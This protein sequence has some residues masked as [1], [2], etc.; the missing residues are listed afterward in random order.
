MQ[1][2]Y[3]AWNIDLNDFW[4]LTSI[5]ERLRFLVGFGVLAPSSHNSQ[6]WKFEIQEKENAII[7]HPDFARSLPY[8]DAN[9]RQLYISLG[10]A[11]ENI[12]VAGTCYGLQPKIQI[13]REKNHI[14][15]VITC[16][17]ISFARTKECDIFI[18][19]ILNRRTNRNKYDSRLPDQKFI[20]YAQGLKT[21][22]IAIDFISDIQKKTA[23]A[24]IVLAATESAMSSDEFRRE[25][26]AYVKSNTTASPIGIPVFGMGIPTL[27]SYIVPF[28]LKYFNMSR[29]SRT[30]DTELLKK[31][32]PM[33]CIISTRDDNE[34]SWIKVGQIYE[35]LALYATHIGISTATMAAPIQIGE[36]YTD[37]QKTLKTSFRPQYFCRVGYT[38]MNVHKSPRL[39]EKSVI[40]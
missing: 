6:P 23:I 7:I 9:N 37:I 1:E 2:N 17:N 40:T 35:Q 18:K 29:I 25:L 31:H 10:C 16:D 13:T 14:L 26:S 30:Q 19:T 15:I 39:M 33:M 3:Q 34:A 20:E 27:M 4:K 28:L 22:A 21:D 5:A 12:L 11:A 24:D 32:T 36:F 8:S 38:N